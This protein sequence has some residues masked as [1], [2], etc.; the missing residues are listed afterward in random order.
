MA[1]RSMSAGAVM[2][3]PGQ[4]SAGALEPG[5]VGGRGA[6]GTRVGVGALY[7]EDDL[8]AAPEDHGRDEVVVEVAEVGQVDAQDHAV[9]A[10]Y[11]ESAGV[12][13]RVLE[14]DVRQRQEGALHG[15]SDPRVALP[16]H[17]Q[18]AVEGL[19]ERG[20]LGGG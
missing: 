12:A 7:G 16:V 11:L 15:V 20:G 14:Q 8:F 1:S 10:T 13:G 4:A 18:A 3:P 2:A 17:G 5:D 9:A 6:V 19:A